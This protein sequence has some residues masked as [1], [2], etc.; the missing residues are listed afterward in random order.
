[1]TAFQVTLIALVEAAVAFTLFGAAIFAAAYALSAPRPAKFR[2]GVN[3]I[4]MAM[5]SAG[6]MIF[7][8]NDIDYHSFLLRF[9]LG[10]LSLYLILSDNSPNRSISAIIKDR[11]QWTLG[12]IA[13]EKAGI[14][15]ITWF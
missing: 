4:A 8:V 14:S 13:A 6:S 9:L 3:A 2:T 10:P 12:F 15:T 1:M 5:I 11:R 7:L